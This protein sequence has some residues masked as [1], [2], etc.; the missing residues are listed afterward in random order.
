[1]AD[2]VHLTKVGIQALSWDADVRRYV[3]K[4]VR[5]GVQL[6]RCACHVEDGV[7]LSDIFRA[8]EQDPELVRF[9]AQ[10]SRC[11]VEAFHAE[12]PKP[13]PETSD[14]LYIEIAKY[15][16]WDEYESHLIVDVSGIAEADESGYAPYGLDFTPVNQLIHLPVRPKAEMQIHND[17]RSLG[18]APCTFT[19]LDV[20]GEIYWEIGFYG[21]PEERNRERAELHGRVREIEEGKATLIPWN[22]SEGLVN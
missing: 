18:K 9:L 6:L 1:M 2:K 20:L 16:E 11:D 21:S 15:F 7:T 17:H 4:K 22:P 8:V 10:W 13:A 5:T 19:L 3:E 14:L 12:A